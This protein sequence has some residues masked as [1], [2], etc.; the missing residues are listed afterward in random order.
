[1]SNFPPE[2]IRKIQWIERELDILRSFEIPKTLYGEGSWEDMRIAGSNIRPGSTA[3]QL[4]AF[5][6]SG[7]LKV[8]MF[9]QNHNDEAHFE[10]QMP[11]SW[12]VGTL[13]YPHVHWTPVSATAGNVVWNLEYAWVSINGT[14][15]A[16]STMSSDATAAGGVAWVH[17]LTRLK[18]GGLDYI[19]GAGR[20]ISSML[21]GRLYRNA[22]V[23]S[24]TLNADVAFLEFDLH[25]QVDGFGSDKESTKS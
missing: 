22:G 14:F 13:V 25:Y 9:E 4:K 20:G 24:D 7:S 8:L 1:M 17:K 18:A 23:G 11:H 2:L 16:P 19:D 15:G 21:V 3:P 5:G 12:K 6:P 10:I